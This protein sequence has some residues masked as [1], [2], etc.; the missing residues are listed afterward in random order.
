MKFF[1]K[2][3]TGFISFL[4]ITLNKFMKRIIIKIIWSLSPIYLWAQYPYDSILDVFR[5]DGGKYKCNAV[6]IGERYIVIPR[7]CFTVFN[8]EKLIIK[9]LKYTNIK[10][11]DLY[12]PVKSVSEN[13]LYWVV[14]VGVKF[15]LGDIIP[16]NPP[17]EPSLIRK[18]T[19]AE[20][21]S[22]E[23][24]SFLWGKINDK[25]FIRG[26]K[27][28]DEQFVRTNLDHYFLVLWIMINNSE[29][30][31]GENNLA[32]INFSKIPTILRDEA[33]AYMSRLI[34]KKWL[35]TSSGITTIPFKANKER[36]G[37]CGDKFKLIKI[38]NKTFEQNIPLSRLIIFC[39]K[40]LNCLHILGHNYYDHVVY[41]Y[42][43]SE[44]HKIMIIDPA[45]KD[46]SFELN[47]SELS[48]YLNKNF[49]INDIVY[50][51][52]KDNLYHNSFF[53][54]INETETTDD[55]FKR[56]YDEIR[57]KDNFK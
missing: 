12:Q 5:T 25:Y 33:D 3:I 42:R 13:T 34:H 29:L 56:V 55:E 17:E 39:K 30:E 7:I 28:S 27:L 16:F 36:E 46:W 37:C 43:D 9:N 38:Y 40:Q 41:A 54:L 20:D 2:L 31:D 22:V 11:T 10:L 23:Y 35:Q 26:L 45:I 49:T 53:S 24:N 52:S 8:K 47:S 48:I 57:K 1:N 21:L 14:K 51:V 6:I 15:D 4:G 44:T 18:I 19:N 50:V 32:G